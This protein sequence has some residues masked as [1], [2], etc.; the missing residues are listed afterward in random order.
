[1]KHSRTAPCTII[2][3]VIVSLVLSGC[4]RQPDEDTL[5]TVNGRKI[6]SSELDKYYKAQTAGAPAQQNSEN[7]DSLKLAILDQLIE[8]EVLL[9][10]ADKL[11]L[12]AT[13]DEVDARM[14]EIKAPYTKE[15]FEQKLREQGLTEDDFR[16]DVRQNLTITKLFNKEITAKINISDA[17]ISNFYNSQKAQF[18]LIEPLWH[19]AQILVTVQPNQQVGS[20]IKNDKAQ[21]ETE[22]KRKIQSILNRLDSGEDFAATAANYSEQPNTAGNGGDMGMIQES[23]LK[24][25]PEL[26]NALQKLKP[27]QYTHI[28][29]VYDNNR[30]PIGYSIVRLLGKEPAGQRE[31]SDPRVQQ[32][33]RQ[34]LRDARSQLL[35]SA[36]FEMLRDQAKVENFYAEQIFKNEAH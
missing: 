25:D 3:L 2:L 24:S 16:R 23:Q 29:T 12:S 19:L 30:R 13:Q 18:N 31:L 9:Q 32:A 21:N 5:A 33:I 36:Y 28:L 8:K 7:A 15:Q 10:R 11:G 14:S 17:D 35:K 22:A 6:S 27:G 26:W 20:N 4:N 1:M 34:Q